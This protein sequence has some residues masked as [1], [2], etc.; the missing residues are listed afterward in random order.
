MKAAAV[1]GS[2]KNFSPI[3]KG[4]KEIGVETNLFNTLDEALDADCDFLVQTNIYCQW[5]DY[6]DLYSKIKET[7]KKILVV[8]SPVFRFINDEFFKWYR[9]SWNSYLFPEAVYPWSESNE[10]W[11]WMCKEYNL[12]LS[13][14]KTD[15]EY[16]TVAL[17]K[18][19]DSSLNSLYSPDDKKPFPVYLR[20]L[21]SI[22]KS[23][24]NLG[25]KRIVLRPHPANND[26]QIQ[27]IINAFPK[28][29]VSKDDTLWKNSKR[30]ITFNSLFALDS[31]YHGIPAISLSETSLHHQFFKSNL[32]QINSEEAFIDRN[33][34][35]NK[36]SYCQWREDE[37]R[38][39]IPFKKLLDL[40]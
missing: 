28:Y 33:N 4:L 1:H 26:T 34:M 3:S 21:T 36:L 14:W 37:I 2:I 20:W 18:F 13:P 29:T 8:E 25:H 5:K 11:D 6:K 30:V 40:I 22:T 17:Q 10:R 31:L 7:N 39:G 35:F 16:I 27:K 15:G 12:K 38:S 32:M 9:L 23:L 24:E 19:N